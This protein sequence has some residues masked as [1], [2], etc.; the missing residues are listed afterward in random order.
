MGC[1]VGS[2]AALLIGDSR[3]AY[4]VGQHPEGVA[5]ACWARPGAHTAAAQLCGEC[6]SRKAQ[7]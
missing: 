3:L 6:P 1:E 7:H 2:A 5:G 4:L